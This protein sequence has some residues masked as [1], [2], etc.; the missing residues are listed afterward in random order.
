VI[1]RLNPGTGGALLVGM[2]RISGTAS[3]ARVVV[4]DRRQARSADGPSVQYDAIRLESN[5]PLLLLPPGVFSP[6]WNFTL[7]SGT[8]WELIRLRRCTESGLDFE[9]IEYSRLNAEQAA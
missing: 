6:T 8:H 5:E 9:M 1:R 7:S 4:N 2:R 3:T